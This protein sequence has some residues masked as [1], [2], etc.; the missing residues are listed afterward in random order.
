MSHHFAKFS[1]VIVD[2]STTNE[3]YT[4]IQEW[5]FLRVDDNSDY[6]DANCICDHPIKYE[7]H[8]TN[9]LNK[10]ELV[11][12][13]KCIER[14]TKEHPDLANIPLVVAVASVESLIT[15]LSKK[16]VG[17]GKYKATKPTFQ[18]VFRKDKAYCQ[19]LIN[20]ATFRE[21][22]DKKRTASNNMS[23]FKQYLVMMGV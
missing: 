17:F 22:V 9:F 6:G 5:V 11:V 4:A 21:P 2:N 12:G 19:W 3:F 1:K 20:N 14:V 7:Y 10:R 13:S 18:E 16:K 15:R 23:E 8:I